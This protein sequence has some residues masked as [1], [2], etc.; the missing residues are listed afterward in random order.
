[1][2]ADLEAILDVRV[3]VVPASDLKPGVRMRA[4]RD[5]VPL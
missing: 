1:M 3:D 4:D 5:L 2:Q